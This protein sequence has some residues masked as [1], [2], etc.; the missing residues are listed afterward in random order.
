MSRVIVITSGKGG[1][2]KSTITASLGRKLAQNGESVVLL[3]T[4][5]GLN[6][7]DVLLGV[8][9]G[10]VYDIVDV[11][12]NRCRVK[13]ALVEVD[14]CKN[15]FVLPSAHTYDESKIDAQS[16]RAVI[17]S[18]KPYFTYI[19][20]DCPAGIERGFHRAVS[21]AD[22]AIVVSTPHLSSVRDGKIAVE[23]IRSYKIDKISVVVNRAR[24]DMEKT[25][26]SVSGVDVSNALGVSL[27]GVVPDADEINAISTLSIFPD[28]KTRADKALDLLCKKLQFGVGEIFD[29]SARYD[30]FIGSIR[31]KFRKLG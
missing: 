23:L 7:L 15:L 30:G 14:E 22:E 21:V 26:D 10:I 29:A 8:E 18:L 9:N 6:N 28:K 1:V 20:I 17:E 11:I 3:D 19:L 16:I 27:L 31:R 12:C 13:Q 25:G 2:G 24:G 5:F 4:D